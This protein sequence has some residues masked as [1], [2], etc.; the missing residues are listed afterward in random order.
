MNL[1]NKSKRLAYLLRH[2]RKYKF[3][4]KGWRNVSDLI[5][6]HGFTFESL[7][8]IVNTNNKQRFEF[9]SDMQYM[10]ARQGHSIQVDVELEECVS[11]S[12]LYHGTAEHFVNDIL[13][14]GL[15]PQNR[16]HVHLS[17]T[18]ET[19]VN[20]GKRHGVPV[21]FKVDSQKMYNNGVKFY[22]SRNGVWL[23]DYVSTEYLSLE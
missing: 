5:N 18:I 12:L 19:A 3:D 13:E 11:P 20:V 17:S 14:E 1:N 21:V 10:R 6:N 23:T 7:Q 4:A 9:S 22:L 8:D 15:K 16:L 2:D